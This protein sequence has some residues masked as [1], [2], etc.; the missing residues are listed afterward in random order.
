MFDI[1]H[2]HHFSKDN[3]QFIENSV[4]CGCF[5]CGRIFPG[6]EITQWIDG[7]KTARCPHC[8]VDSLLPEDCGHPVT[9]EFLKQM[10]EYWFLT[11]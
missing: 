10:N 6:S 3:R 9:D 8:S 5:Y 7:G 1:L 11:T 2:A 4:N